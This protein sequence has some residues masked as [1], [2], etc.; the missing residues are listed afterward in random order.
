[1][2]SAN[3]PSEIFKKEAAKHFVQMAGR[4]MNLDPTL[5]AKSLEEID[6]CEPEAFAPPQA[7]QSSEQGAS[8]QA[9]AGA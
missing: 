1:M 6:S 5:V 3:I 2:Q 8:T 7:D 4:T 9:L